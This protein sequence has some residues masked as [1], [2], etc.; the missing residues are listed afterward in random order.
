[1]DDRT[2][3]L[4]TCAFCPNTCRRHAPPEL[5][6]L[7]ESHTPSALCLLALERLQG[8]LPDDE[9]TRALLAERRFVQAVQPHCTYG[10][11]VAALLDAAL[12][13]PAGAAR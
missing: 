8:R 11:D 4:R 12:A 7:P 2:R 1:M 9:A 10:L 6:V 5:A 13:A 3:A